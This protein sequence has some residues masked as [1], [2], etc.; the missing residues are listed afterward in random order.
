MTVIIRADKEARFHEH[1]QTMVAIKS[2]GFRKLQ[3][4]AEI[5][6]NQ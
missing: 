1:P 6:S 3:L 2:A 5:A 4:R